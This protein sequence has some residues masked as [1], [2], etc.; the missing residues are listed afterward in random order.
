LS[1]RV[2][3]ALFAIVGSERDDAWD[4][5]MLDLFAG[6]GAAAIEAL[7]RGAPAA[8]LVEVDRRAA[9][10]ARENLRLAGVAG[11]AG[12]VLR[13]AVGLLRAGPGALPTGPGPFGVV[14]VDPPYDRPELV[15]GC[16]EA[17]GDPDRGWL[18]GSACVVAKHFWRSRPPER[19][20]VLALRRERRFGETA[21][22]V[23]R[24]T[25]QPEVRSS[26]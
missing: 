14:V 11:R 26:P 24:P 7:S 17:L 4:V 6:S 16:L 19:S 22:S 23:Y 21:L 8:V 9:D 3:Q 2:K 1:D 20:G 18:D 12:V 10:V 13:D 15:V 25:E 5:A